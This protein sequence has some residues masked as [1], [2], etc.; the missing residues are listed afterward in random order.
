M[1]TL[2]SIAALACALC[3]G[4]C[5]TYDTGGPAPVPLGDGVYTIGA[6]GGYDAAT[7]PHSETYQR[8]IRFC[9]EQGRQLVRLDRQPGMP[10]QAGSGMQ[11]R[12]V[13]PGEPEWKEPVG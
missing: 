11:F 8:A 4:A 13:G 12:C 5:A 6:D 3:L 9:F 10:Q 7:G 1:S 2:A